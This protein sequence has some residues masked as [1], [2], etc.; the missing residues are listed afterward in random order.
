MGEI[1]G[2][3][4]MPLYVVHLSSKA[5]LEQVRELRVKGVRIIVETT[6]HYL[7]LDRSKLEGPDGSL[8]VL[9]PPL[10]TKEDNE[11]LQEALLNGEIQVVATDHCSFSFKGQ[12][13][14]GRGDFS[15]I[16]NGLPGVEHRPALMYTYGVAAGKLS[17]ER[18]SAACSENIARLYGMFPKKGVLAPGAD[19]DVVVWDPE[20]RWQITAAAQH[21][22]CD[23]TP[24]EGYEVQGRAKAV[25]L[26]GELAAADG[27]PLKTGLGRYVFREESMV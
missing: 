12:K 10:R 8:Y 7:F 11:A 2:E 9:T 13:E 27:E 14:L 4:K 21:M 25:F 19:A 20:A 22:T 17:A 23:Y 18:F 15:K 26:G 6:P 5:G 24:Y 3:L 16:P 1:A